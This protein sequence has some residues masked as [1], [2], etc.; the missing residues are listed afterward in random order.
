[1]TE[2]KEPTQSQDPGPFRWALFSPPALCHTQGDLTPIHKAIP[3]NPSML[4]PQH[5][6]W[7]SPAVTWSA[8][9]EA[10]LG[11]RLIQ[12]LVTISVTFGLEI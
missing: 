12:G 8:F 9:R 2:K 5:L 4:Y 7:N 11:R 1:M 3:A 6:G 10:D